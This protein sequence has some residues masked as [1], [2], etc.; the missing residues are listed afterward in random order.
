VLKAADRRPFD[1]SKVRCFQC[2]QYWHMKRKCPE[3][4]GRSWRGQARAP[5]DAVDTS[6]AGKNRWRVQR[7]AGQVTW[8]CGGQVCCEL[9]C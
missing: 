6:A 5:K 8:E 9:C 2:R 3:G 1:T 4:A 7:E